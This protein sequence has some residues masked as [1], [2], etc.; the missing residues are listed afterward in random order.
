MRHLQQVMCQRFALSLRTLDQVLRM[1]QET[2]LPGCDRTDDV[3]SER[4]RFH[5]T[6]EFDPFRTSACPKPAARSRRRQVSASAGARRLSEHQSRAPHEQETQYRQPP[7]WQG[8]NRRRRAR[9][10]AIHRGDLA[11]RQR[12]ISYGNFVDTSIEE[13]GDE[14]R[15]FTDR[16]L[17][18]LACVSG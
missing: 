2:A 1:T 8:G 14:Y 13:A 10:A 7:D 15:T 4:L 6:T 5:S 18:R 17:R 12:I 11:C 3:R 16:K 9:G